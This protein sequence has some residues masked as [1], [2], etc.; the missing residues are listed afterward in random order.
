[1]QVKTIEHPGGMTTERVVFD[2]GI[3]KGVYRVQV[4]GNG[5]SLLSNIIKN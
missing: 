3:S 4:Q 1:V 5:L 2:K